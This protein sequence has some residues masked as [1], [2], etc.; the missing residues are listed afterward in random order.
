MSVV[1]DILIPFCFLRKKYYI[2]CGPCGII[3]NNADDVDSDTLSICGI[4]WAWGTILN[5]LYL[6]MNLY[7]GPMKYNI[8]FHS[9]VTWQET[10]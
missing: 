6:S 10:I 1:F 9:I 2:L 3:N 4:W 8:S 5:V 7:T